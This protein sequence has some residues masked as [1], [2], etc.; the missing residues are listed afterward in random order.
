MCCVGSGK[1]T[2][3]VGVEEI[4][5]DNKFIYVINSDSPEISKKIAKLVEKGISLTRD[6]SPLK[7]VV[8]E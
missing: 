8:I 3:D 5:V 7:C 1:F 6:T 2:V 4:D